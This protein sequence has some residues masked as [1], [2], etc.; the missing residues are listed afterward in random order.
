MLNVWRWG[1]ESPP[2]TPSDHIGRLLA[3]ITTYTPKLCQ[4]IWEIK[5]TIPSHQASRL[6]PQL[7]VMM[8]SYSIWTNFVYQTPRPVHFLF[9]PSLATIGS[10]T[11]LALRTASW[12]TALVEKSPPARTSQQSVVLQTQK[13]RIAQSEMKMKTNRPDGKE[14]LLPKI[15]GERKDVGESSDEVDFNISGNRAPSENGQASMDTLLAH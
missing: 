3:A 11:H 10:T 8:T 12:Q 5:N 9:C 1:T 2:L 7:K 4:A 14:S 13:G 6:F 15:D